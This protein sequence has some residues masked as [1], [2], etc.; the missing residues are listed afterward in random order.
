MLM[1]KL[2]YIKWTTK[3]NY[4]GNQI[5]N[6]YLTKDEAKADKDYLYINDL[7][8]RFWIVGTY[9]GEHERSYISTVEID[10]NEPTLYF[11]KYENHYEWTTHGIYVF[12]CDEDRNDFIK[13]DLLNSFCKDKQSVLDDIN[14]NRMSQFVN[15]RKDQICIKTFELNL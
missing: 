2:I 9:D 14:K 13:N 4:S 7:N 5:L 6:I 11:V 15:T 1:P 12:M 3:S 8:Q 10:E